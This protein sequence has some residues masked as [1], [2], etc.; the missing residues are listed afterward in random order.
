MP[1]NSLTLLRRAPPAPT[2]GVNNVYRLLHQAPPAPR[3]RANSPGTPR[4]S[5]RA[6]GTRRSSANIRQQAAR[7]NAQAAELLRNARADVNRL[8]TLR[9]VSQIRLLANLA[10]QK[11]EQSMRLRR[12]ALRLRKTA[13]GR[14]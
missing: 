13:R 9:S 14:S 12:L 3:H 10:R 1:T 7:L 4:A 5:A 11:R 8:R 2:H 6:P